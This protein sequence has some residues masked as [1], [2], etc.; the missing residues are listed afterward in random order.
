MQYFHFYVRELWINAICITE[1]HVKLHY[2]LNKT[3]KCPVLKALHICSMKILHLIKRKIGNIY[4]KIFHFSR[5]NR[6]FYIARNKRKGD[7]NVQYDSYPIIGTQ[8]HIV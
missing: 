5:T 4:M 7:N 3:E 8:M 1:G 2:S 6:A